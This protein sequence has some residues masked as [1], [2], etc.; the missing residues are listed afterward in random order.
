MERFAADKTLIAANVH[1]CFETFTRAISAGGKF[2]IGFSDSREFVFGDGFLSNF[3]SRDAPHNPLLLLPLTPVI[4]VLFI[5]PAAFV[6]SPELT[7]IRLSDAEVE[8][9]NGTSQ[10]Y[11]KDQIFFRERR[12]EFSE[13]FAAHEF[14]EFTYHRHP[15]LDQL[16]E[17]LVAFRQSR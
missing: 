5:K 15:I 2:M 8:F 9:V 14:L 11:S 4:V 10:V 13:H 12:P 17:D 6:R 16:I 3:V 7:T 1:G